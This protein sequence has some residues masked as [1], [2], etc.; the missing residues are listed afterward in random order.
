MLKSTGNKKDCHEFEMVIESLQKM[1]F[2]ENK[3]GQKILSVF[4]CFPLRF[5]I[6]TG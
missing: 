2:N 1:S 6:E 4:L 5:I 3:K